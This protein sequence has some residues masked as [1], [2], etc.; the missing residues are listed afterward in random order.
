MSNALENIQLHIP[1]IVIERGYVLFEECWFRAF[2]FFLRLVQPMGHDNSCSG[3][4]LEIL[5]RDVP[6]KIVEVCEV[7]ERFMTEASFSL[8]KDSPKY[9]NNLKLIDQL[10]ILGK[11]RKVGSPG[12]ICAALESNG[13]KRITLIF[14]RVKNIYLVLNTYFMFYSSFG[15]LLLLLLC[16]IS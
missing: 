1:S 9:L 10:F 6:I 13:T 11:K 8:F 15:L 12:I 16:S 14:K 4:V 2:C 7:Y 5:K 3:K